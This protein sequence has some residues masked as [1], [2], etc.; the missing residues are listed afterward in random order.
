MFTLSG[1]K[2]TPHGREYMGTISTTVSGRTCQAW[3]SDTPHFPDD[4]ASN[5]DN[6]PDGSRAAAKN[7]CR[8]PDSDPE[9][10]WCYTTDPNVRWESCDVPYCNGSH[11]MSTRR[12]LCVFIA[13]SQYLTRCDDVCVPTQGRHGRLA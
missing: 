12:L 7:Y 10:L 13:I 9:G 11:G 8:N 3:T 2:W 1:C 4:H 5:D 6:Y